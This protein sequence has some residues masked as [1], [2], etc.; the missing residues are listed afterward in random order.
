LVTSIAATPIQ[1]RRGEIFL[2]SHHHGRK[3]F[4]QTLNKVTQGSLSPCALSQAFSSTLALDAKI[5]SS[6]GQVAAYL[7]QSGEFKSPLL[8]TLDAP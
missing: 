1:T 3:P 4:P 7:Y 2:P 8:S 5:S 6:S